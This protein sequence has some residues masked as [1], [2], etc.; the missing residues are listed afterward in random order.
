MKNN[1]AKEPLQGAKS[2]CGPIRRL[3]G[4]ALL[5]LPAT[6]LAAEVQAATGQLI[7]GNTPG[8][9]SRAKN[10]GP[11]D[12]SKVISVTLWLRLHNQGGLDALAKDLYDKNSPNYR[13]WLKAADLRE[14]FAC[15]DDEVKIVKQFL[16]ERKLK[17][18]HIGPANVSVTAEGAVGDVEKAFYIR[19]DRF[20]V[21]G[22]THR[23]NTDDPYIEGPAGS[24]VTAVSGLSDVPF[25]PQI[26]RPVDPSTG[27][28]YAGRP[29]GGPSP[30][31]LVFEGVCFRPPETV[32]FNTNGGLPLA[33]YTGNRYGS[34]ITSSAPGTLPPCGYSPAEVRTAY[35][36][37][38]LYKEGH[39]GKGQTIVIVDAFGSPTI[40]QDANVF[41]T[42][43][44]LPPLTSSNFNLIYY[45]A[46]P[47]ESNSDWA[48]ETTLDVEWAHAIAPDATIDLV[49]APT[50]Y[51]SDLSAAQ[52][53]AIF[54]LPGVA[55]SN[56]WGE[57]E[58]L[59]SPAI[60]DLYNALG[61]L[62]ASM[63][64]SVNY[65]SGDDG[66]FTD[67]GIPA[68]VSSPASGQWATAVG[69][70]S[71]ALNSDKTMAFQTGWGNNFTRIATY[72]PNP[73]I[74]PPLSLGFYAGAGG[75]PS[76][77][78][79]KPS[80][81]EGL[82]GNTRLVPDISWLADPYTGVEIVEFDPNVGGP[83]ISVIG[84]TSVACPMFSALW[85]IANQV[86]GESAPLGLAAQ[87]VYTL[88]AGAV[89]DVVPVGSA[90]NVSGTI[91]QATSPEVTHYTPAQLAAPLENTT[92]FYSAL[93]NSNTTRWYVLSF[94]TDSGL[95][96]AVGW[97]NVTGVG[98]PNGQTF[99]DAFTPAHK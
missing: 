53:Y 13:H 52:L 42:L 76:G 92:T 88:P 71:L 3:C 46:P 91:Y 33:T 9:V 61:E 67:V 29:L 94:G 75:G 73:P 25:K 30:N 1:N 74:V 8:F 22:E 24:L 18:T 72:S 20:S 79:S 23:A 58:S 86:A 96:T 21:A 93:Y 6:L 5:V 16:T 83:A 19:I 50:N 97:D 82:K 51:D 56:S 64:I 98:T 2:F 63:G 99:A 62:A 95:K 17:V 81:Q 14:K 70:V 38:G 48:G 10:L 32:T 26:V 78:F 54:N 87:Y 35:N 80:F 40:A 66:D 39:G 65:S 4:L 11:E 47:T 34:D 49:I 89:T 68:T 45:P 77:F 43:Y 57:P 85:A 44:G 55:I 84:G 69:G 60:L 59:T 36:L 27:K 90:N 15:S 12:T 31:G 28:P 37:N 7:V 41:S